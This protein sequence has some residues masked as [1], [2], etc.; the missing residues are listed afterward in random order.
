MHY[1]FFQIFMYFVHMAPIVARSE[2]VQHVLVYMYQVDRDAGSSEK[3]ICAA[4]FM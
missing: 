2:P 4:K 3:F 1:I